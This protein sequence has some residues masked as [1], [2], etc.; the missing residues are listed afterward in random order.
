MK[1]I[2]DIPKDFA[3]HFYEDRFKNSLERI[4]ADLNEDFVF[5]GNYERELLDMLITSFGNANMVISNADIEEMAED[6]L[7]FYHN[8]FPSFS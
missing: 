2:V 1:L 7:K 4:E 5:A 3:E 8:P 6:D